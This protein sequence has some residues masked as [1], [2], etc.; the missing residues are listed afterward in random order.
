MKCCGLKRGIIYLT[1]LDGSSGCIDSGAIWKEA[2][3][4][5][6]KISFWVL[7]ELNLMP[8]RSLRATEVKTLAELAQF[9]TQQQNKEPAM[10]QIVSWKDQVNRGIP[11]NKIAEGYESHL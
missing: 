4:F 8:K 9:Y 6:P 7:S 1:T 10:V 3:V 5:K 2:N 11:I